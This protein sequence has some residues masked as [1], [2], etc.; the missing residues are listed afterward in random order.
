VEIGPYS[1]EQLL[2]I[3]RRS[4]ERRQRISAAHRGKPKSE[5]HRRAISIGQANRWAER[6]AAQA[7]ASS[8]QVPTPAGVANA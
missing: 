4:L 7:A 3:A 8:T 5:E 1:E 2:D 6:R